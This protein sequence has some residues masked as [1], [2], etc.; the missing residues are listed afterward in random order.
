LLGLDLVFVEHCKLG[1]PLCTQ[2]C[3]EH[4]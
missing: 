1:W 4:K 3:R 2:V